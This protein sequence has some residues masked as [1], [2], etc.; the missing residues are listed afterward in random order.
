MTTTTSTIIIFVDR[1]SLQESLV[2]FRSVRSRYLVV[3][4]LEQ[5]IR[6]TLN[7]FSLWKSNSLYHYAGHVFARFNVTLKCTLRFIVK[8]DAMQES[9]STKAIFLWRGGGEAGSRENL[10]WIKFPES[11]FVVV[12]S[13]RTNW[14]EFLD[15]MWMTLLLLCLKDVIIPVSFHHFFTAD[16]V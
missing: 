9:F 2:P 13:T 16:R 8:G 5:C 7:Q 15:E 14:E 10:A 11:W 12:Y 3:S 4:L 6:N 1:A